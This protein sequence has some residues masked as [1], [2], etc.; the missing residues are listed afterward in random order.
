MAPW[1]MAPLWAPT[2]PEQL[3]TAAWYGLRLALV[4]RG[5]KP[6]RPDADYGAT[7]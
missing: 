3:P 7:G 6:A 1:A 5:W 2:G 4:G